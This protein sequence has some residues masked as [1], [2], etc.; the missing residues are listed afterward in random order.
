MIRVDAYNPRH[1]PGIASEIGYRPVL[2]T[3]VSKGET[4]LRKEQGQWG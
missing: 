4:V 3:Y 2:S 1:K